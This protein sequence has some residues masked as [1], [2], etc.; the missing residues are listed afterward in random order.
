MLSRSGSSTLA[1]DRGERE[2]EKEQIWQNLWKKVPVLRRRPTRKPFVLF[3]RHNFLFYCGYD[4]RKEHFDD[5]HRSRL[6]H[7]FLRE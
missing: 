5:A 7:D 1:I 2:R 4:C 3:L 6:K